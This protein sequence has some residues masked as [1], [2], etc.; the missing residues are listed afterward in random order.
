MNREGSK[1]ALLALAEAK[2]PSALVELERDRAAPEA[3]ARL[4]AMRG[5]VLLGEVAAAA[6][7]LA[8]ADPHVRMA[9]SCTILSARE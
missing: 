6:E 3:S 7:L 1:A 4:V 5:L 2:D 8:D 9:T